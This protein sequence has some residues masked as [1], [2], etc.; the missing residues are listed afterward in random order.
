MALGKVY[1]RCDKIIYSKLYYYHSRAAQ[2]SNQI[3]N[4]VRDFEIALDLMSINVQHLDKL[5]DSTYLPIF[6]ENIGMS[7]TGAGFYDNAVKYLG[8]VIEMGKEPNSPV[9]CVMDD[10]LQYLGSYHLWKG[11]LTRAKQLLSKAILNRCSAN[12]ENCGGTLYSLDNVYL[13][14]ERF[15]GAMEMH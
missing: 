1:K 14:Q 2:E 15:T 9:S 5:C 11:N 7:S 3:E 6:Y 8:K 10:F 4:V 13:R 12:N